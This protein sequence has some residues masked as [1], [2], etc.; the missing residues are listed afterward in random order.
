MRVVLSTFS[1]HDKMPAAVTE[2]RVRSLDAGQ[3][4]NQ[5]A[6]NLT[7]DLDLCELQGVARMPLLM[8]GVGIVW[9]LVPSAAASRPESKESHFCEG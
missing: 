4:A 2:G 7:D 3:A 9:S 6:G 8:D 5:L 1:C